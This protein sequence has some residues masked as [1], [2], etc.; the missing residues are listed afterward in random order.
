MR[1]HCRS[2]SRSGARWSARSTSNPTQRGSRAVACLST[3]VL[4]AEPIIGTPHPAKASAIMTMPHSAHSAASAEVDRHRLSVVDLWRRRV[5]EAPRDDD[6]CTGVDVR[7]GVVDPSL[8]EFLRNTAAPRPC[9]LLTE[10]EIRAG[11]FAGHRRPPTLLTVRAG[12]LAK[13]T[14]PVSAQRGQMAGPKRAA[15]L[16]PHRHKSY[17]R[18]SG[19]ST[20]AIGRRPIVSIGISRCLCLLG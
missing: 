2:A 18:C 14:H 5:H 11:Y 6:G 9:G 4:A 15:H 10:D 13:C 20:A 7:V 12:Y 17:P 1:Q 3:A 8:T 19:Q 16:S